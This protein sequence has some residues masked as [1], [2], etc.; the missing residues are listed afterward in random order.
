M[1]AFETWASFATCESDVL[2]Y[3]CAEKRRVA[4]SRIFSRVST[5]PVTLPQASESVNFIPPQAQPD[6]AARSR[7]AGARTMPARKPPMC[8]QKATPPTPE[9]SPRVAT[10][11]TNCQ[12]NQIARK[13]TAGTSTTCTKRKIGTR[14]T[15]RERSEEHTSEL[16]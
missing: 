11:E 16:Q 15:T 12:T 10:P 2:V 8:A 4:V 3:P 5:G 1:S 14:V 9:R 7:S 6:G 13:K